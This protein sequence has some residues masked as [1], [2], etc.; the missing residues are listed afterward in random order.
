[1]AVVA[2]R[3]RVLRLKKAH[4]AQEAFSRQ[5][6]ESQ[7]RERKR[8]A[9]E[10]HDSLGQSLAIIKNRAA[11][12]L[13]RPEE[14]EIAIEQLDE[15]STAA[16]YAIDEVREIAYNLRPYQLDRLGLTKALE[17]M[18]KKVA[19]SDGLR[20]TF[21]IDQID[22]VFAPESE[23]NLYR[24]MQESLSNVLKHSE[25]TQANVSIKRAEEK[26]EIIVRDNGKGFDP[27]FPA[28]RE[29][30]KGGFG[31]IGISERARMLGGSYSIVSAPG[32]GTTVTVK[33]DL[34]ER[35]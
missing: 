4:A 34:R 18:L 15:I 13:S 33:L 11:L 10:L 7:E 2:Y 17:A 25:A 31:L 5:L 35:R 32:E 19:A 1:M 9:A 22:D 23:I 14:H 12:S 28:Q 21:E 29:A 24:I 27:G 8:I 30:G 16:T 26:M 3:Y 6:I 20:L